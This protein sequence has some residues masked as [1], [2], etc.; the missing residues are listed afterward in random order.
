ML[1]GK[2]PFFA[3]VISRKLRAT[4]QKNYRCSVLITIATSLCYHA[5]HL[6]HN[7]VKLLHDVTHVKVLVLCESRIVLNV[8][9]DDE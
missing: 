7:V 9:N 5:D 6:Y 8:K 2:V 3:Y 1:P 4:Q